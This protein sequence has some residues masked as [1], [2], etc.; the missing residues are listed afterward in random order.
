MRELQR[1]P[2]RNDVIHVDFI[3]VDADAEILVEVSGGITLK[4]APADA[5]A[6][7]DLLSMGALTHSSPTLDLGLDFVQGG[8]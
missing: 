6:G 1:H 2:V 7:V 4:T 5:Q 8:S 3:R